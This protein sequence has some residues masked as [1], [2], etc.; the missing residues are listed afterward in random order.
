[1]RK[2][3]K[4]FATN[5]IKRKAKP[6][7]KFVGRIKVGYLHINN[8]YK[9]NRIFQFPECYALEKI[10]GTSAH[11]SLKRAVG[12]GEVQLS[13]FSGGEKY[14]NFV[15]LFLHLNIIQTFYNHSEPYWDELVIFGEAYGGKQQGM[16]L[17]YGDALKFVAFDVKINHVWLN[18]PE[19]EKIVKLFG[20]EFV[21]YAR[22]P[23]LLS[24][25]DEERNKPSTQAKRN[26]ILDDKVREG[27]V[28]RPLTETFDNRGNRII[29][30]HKNDIFKET[31]RTRVVDVNKLQILTD[32]N[33]IAD[34]WVTE[35]RLLHVLDKIGPHCGI[36]STKDV[37]KAM[38]EDIQREAKGEII[39]SKEA[40]RAIGSATARLF[41]NLLK[42][43][44]EEDH[45]VRG[46]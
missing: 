8:L 7:I 4:V 22:I 45:H 25:I 12:S 9:D 17:T 20:L 34:E 46:M 14:E 11:I 18:V 15:N 43:R 28:L 39:E 26:G 10:H 40:M 27:V 2:N 41:K 6:K 42:T 44:F 38:I 5:A 36:E 35:M 24:R 23:T 32:A 1:M 3:Y 13:Y 21:D 31:T 16:R 33:K 37:I 19:A 29:S 30:K